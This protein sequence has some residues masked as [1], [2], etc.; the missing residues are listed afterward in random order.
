MKLENILLTSEDNYHIKL[1]DFG[2]AEIIEKNKLVSRSGTPGFLPP[3]IF[4]LKP[5]TSKG[6]MFSVGVILYCMLYGSSPFRGDTYKEVIDNNRNCQINYG[7]DFWKTVSPNCLEVL[8]KLLS[9]DPDK[10]FSA[11][12]VLKSAWI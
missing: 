2:F 11:Q 9:I 1:I 7:L 6:D 8:K 10:R 3:E 4:K 12:D 5:F